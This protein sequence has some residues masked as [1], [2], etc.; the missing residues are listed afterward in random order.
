M[1]RP[2]LLLRR[3]LRLIA[4]L[5]FFGVLFSVFE[6]SG[7]RSH[8]SLDF[9][10]SQ[11]HE[12][13]LGGLAI[14]VLLFCLANLIQIPGLIF[15]AAAVLALGTVMG[16]LATYLAASISCVV[17]FLVIRGIG[18]D[19]LRQLDNRL[20]L[21]IFRRLDTRPVPSV[22]LLRMLFQTFPQVNYALA[23][24]GV[25]FR[26]HLAGTLLGL[27]VPI[28]ILAVLLDFVVLPI[29]KP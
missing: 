25:K 20:A 2:A 9:L 19:A 18:G 15:L 28:A 12:H 5:L 7:L 27:P 24:S 1:A 14:Y 6:L 29:G 4:V 10:K 22:G 26:H 8:F 3:H 21:R 11:I 13:V 17:M 23:L 16:G